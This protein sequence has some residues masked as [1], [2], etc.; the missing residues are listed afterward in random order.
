[1]ATTTLFP[2]P[3]DFQTKRQLRAMS[4]YL[5]KPVVAE[6]SHNAQVKT[7]FVTALKAA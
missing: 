7:A 3:I 1:M 5:N 2:Q 6:Q 4:R